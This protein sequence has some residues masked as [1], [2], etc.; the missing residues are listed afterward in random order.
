MD[1]DAADSFL[2]TLHN[3]M[4]LATAALAAAI[5]DPPP[6]T[7]L[8]CAW[9]GRGTDVPTDP[10]LYVGTWYTIGVATKSWYR[11]HTCTQVKI[12][13]TQDL[14]SN[15]REYGAAYF[16]SNAY[17][18]TPNVNRS[19]VSATLKA[20][21]LATFNPP[22]QLQFPFPGV[23]ASDFYIA[24]T[25]GDGTPNGISAIATYTCQQGGY[26]NSQLFYLSRAPYFVAPATQSR[27][28]EKVAKSVAN[29][30]DI[31]MDLVPQAQGWCDYEWDQHILA[32]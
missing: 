28:A 9:T 30:A 10:Q 23:P 3:E 21:D 25:D 19:V 6:M 31:Q 2:Y 20:R 15:D 1:F 32:N 7:G 8:P 24:A 11:D 12:S 14:F 29:A 18:D 5:T 26:N 4:L 16:G 22:Y 27:L 17:Q 13:P